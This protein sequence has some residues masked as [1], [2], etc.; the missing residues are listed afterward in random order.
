MHSLHGQVLGCHFPISFL[1][2]FNDVSCLNSFGIINLSK[3]NHYSKKQMT[4]EKALLTFGK[5]NYEN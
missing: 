2:V 1:K 5:L 4:H 3:K